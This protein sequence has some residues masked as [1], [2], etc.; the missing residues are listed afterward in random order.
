[1]D[2]IEFVRQFR[3]GPFAVFDI[4]VSYLAVFLLASRLTNLARKAK[5]HILKAQWLWLV[6]PVSVIIHLIFGQETP[7]TRMALDPNNSYLLK[8][9]I[10]FM[11]FMGLRGIRITKK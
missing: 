9:V 4:A 6:L 8:L 5:L 1:M 11:I 10:L 3:I 2:F 7:L